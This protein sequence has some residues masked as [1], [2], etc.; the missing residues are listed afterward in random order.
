[1]NPLH[2]I[3]PKIRLALYW[4][5]YILGVVSSGIT[6]VWGSIAAASPDVTMP[7]G[8]VV[9]QGVVTMLT[10]QLNLLAGSNLPS[11]QDVI[12]GEVTVVATPDPLGGEHRG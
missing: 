1:M 2:Q 9:T 6:V 10:T 5:G 8:L 7:L 4:S 12:D 11:A 3:P